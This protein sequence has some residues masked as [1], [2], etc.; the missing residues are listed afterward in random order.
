MA[1]EVIIQEVAAR[2][3]V[4]DSSSL[5]DQRTLSLIVAATLQA[6]EEQKRLAQ[7]QRSDTRLPGSG[8][9]EPA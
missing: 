7:R 1:D 2:V 8:R 6:F 5:L 3:R 9:D 4:L